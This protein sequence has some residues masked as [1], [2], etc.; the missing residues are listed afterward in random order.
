MK[1]RGLPLGAIEGRAQRFETHL[2]PS[3]ALPKSEGA[4]DVAASVAGGA[5]PGLDP[6]LGGGAEPI[7]AA[8]E[9]TVTQA[10]ITAPRRE[11]IERWR[12]AGGRL[13]L[14]RLDLAKGPRRLEAK[15]ELSLDDQRRPAG[16]SSLRRPV[17]AMSSRPSWGGASRGRRPASSGGSCS[18][19]T[20][21]LRPSADRKRAG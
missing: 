2:R 10:R 13:L 7:E 4:Y 17:S 11:E 6:L 21:S 1:L 15:G 3:P 18:P 9:A 16:Q 12:E 14:T 8:L 5:A 20:G 19:A